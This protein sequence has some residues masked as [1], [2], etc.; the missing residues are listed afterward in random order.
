M[1]SSNSGPEE[2]DPPRVS[3]AL[4]EQAEL[5]NLLTEHAHEFIRLHQVDGRSVYASRSVERLYGRAPATL[6]EFAHPDDRGAGQAWWQEVLAGGNPGR[7]LWRVRDS[8]GGWRWLET[9]GSLV[10]FGGQ[11]H[12]LTVCRD[13]TERKEAEE[14]LQ[15]SEA[16]AH[17]A[18]DT[19]PVQ[20]WSGPADGT[21][22]YCNYPWRA[23]AGLTLEEIKGDGWQQILHPEDREGVL[24]AW[25]ESMTSGKPYEREERHRRADGTYHWF[26]CRG[27]PLRDAEGR[28][29]RWYGANTDIEDRKH[30][31][32]ALRE[33]ERTLNEAQRIAHLGH[34][35]QDLETGRITASDEAYHIFG[36]TP[37]EDL[38]TWEAWQERLHPEDRPL[39]A[40]A[41]E[42][43][44]QEGPRYEAEYR[45]IRPDGEVRMVHSQ[46]E[47]ER[48]REGRPRRLFGI[49]FDVTEHRRAEAARRAAEHRLEHVVVSSPA[50]LFTIPIED[51][52]FR[53]IGWMS[54]NVEA[55]LGYRVE[56][57]LGIDWWKSNI[58]PEQQSAVVN[59]FMSEILVRGYSAAEY[60]FRHKDGPYRWLRGEA[61]LLRD[62]A[63][64]PVEVVGSLSDIT[65]R[66]RLEDRFR[67]SQKMEAIGHLA[68]GVAHDFNN[69]LTIILGYT[70][71]LLPTLPPGDPKREMVSQI[72]EAGERAAGLTRQL[73]AFSRQTVLEPKVLDLNEV[74]LENEKMLRRLIGEDVQLTTHLDP[75]LEPVRLD[76]GQIGQVIMNLA[77]NA[78]DAMPTGGKLVIE[79]APFTLNDTHAGVVSEAK[80]GRYVLLA[81]RDTGTGITPEVR[82]HL[83]E[84][85]F[86]TK[87]PGKGTGLGLATVYG[88][89]KQS[90]G[91]I[92]VESEPGRGTAFKL[93]FP[94][95]SG[96][97]T[98]EPSSPAQKPLAC[99]T[100]TIL[101]VEDEEALRAM[102]STVLRQAGYRVLEAGQGTEA[103]RLAEQHPEP[104]HL[105]I[106]D[107]VMPEMG[108]RE[109][110]ER[111]CQQRPDLKVLYL[112]GYTDD[113]VVRHGVLQEGMAFLQKPFKLAALTSKVRQVLEDPPA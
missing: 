65:E 32:H 77:V 66:K 98:A 9:S 105:L 90:G 88:I 25:R 43:A 23:Y 73:L 36:L 113:A 39:R 111:L 59:Q 71:V 53:G 56:E 29:E 89:V 44:L 83:F 57:T 38:R 50:I 8:Q 63:G 97:A 94:V 110:V 15:R 5:Y 17:R 80:P 85:F 7:L 2:G 31:E 18:L 46:G 82:A 12:V 69:L 61:R 100:E 24:N 79:T 35:E 109:L 96:R 67:Q 87:E 49:L 1:P 54:E 16:Q 6:F 19:I 112:S 3:A 10:R 107:V 102:A 52:E 64:R 62:A 74:V 4:H 51:G 75:T 58:H 60:Q 91:F 28:V 41:I 45:V 68:G 106:T 42:R 84:P 11:P 20:I 34:W 21:L 55:L 93:Y 40:A 104:I 81:I 99:G 108:G 101:L 26:L 13:I 47:V 86:T 70:E 92:C 33:S 76:P 22:D 103:L 30:A 72:W 78:R 27:L 37:Q 95:A 48:D 14:R